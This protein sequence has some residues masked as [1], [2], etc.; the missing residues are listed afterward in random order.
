MIMA[1]AIKGAGDTR[2]VMWVS[3]IMATVLGILTYTV[4]EVLNL[5]VLSCWALV[6]VWVCVFGMIFLVRFM[7]GRWKSLRVIEMQHE[8]VGATC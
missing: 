6:T 8:P 5:G 1:S 4:V 7:Q 2:F 3:L